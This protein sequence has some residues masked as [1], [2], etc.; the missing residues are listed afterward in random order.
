MDNKEDLDFDLEDILQEFSDHSEDYRDS[1]KEPEPV[2]ELGDTIRLDQVRQAVKAA[3]PVTTDT[4]PFEK[5]GG[6]MPLIEPEEPQAPQEPQV[7][8]FSENWEPEYDEPMGDYPIPEPIVFR[9]KSRLKELR[10]K[11]VA[12]PEKMYYALTRQGVGKLQLSMLLCFGI[13]LFC[14]GFTVLYAWGVVPKDRLRL[15]VFVQFL[16]M[17]MSALL[18]CNRLMEGLGDLLR[19]RF[20]VNTL[21]VCTLAVCCV[22]AVVC[23]QQTRIPVSAAFGLE[24]TMAMWSAYNRRSTLIG[25]MDTLRKATML[26]SVVRVQ[27]CHGGQSGF[28]TG[29]GEVEHYMDSYAEISTPEKVLDWYALGALVVSIAVGIIGGVRHGFGLGIQVCAGSL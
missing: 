17:L 1:A 27:D 26:D 4:V 8:P 2:Q 13:F 14:A 25:E 18:G 15:L 7:E 6:A 19:L 3:Q 21:L 28:R 9:P 22:D 5:V 29:R 24:M 20:S 11:L 12:G 10:S 23:L 16:G